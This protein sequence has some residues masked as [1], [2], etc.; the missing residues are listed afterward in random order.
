MKCE[1]CESVVEEGTRECPA[2][3]AQI[4]TP[5]IEPKTSCMRKFQSDIGRGR[6]LSWKPYVCLGWILFL[7]GVINSI[8]EIAF[9][10]SWQHLSLESI[11]IFFIDL[12]P[13]N[14]WLIIGY[15]RKNVNRRNGYDLLK[16][17]G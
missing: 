16:K 7:G 8:S 12:I 13:C 1:Y 3:G 14:I 2:C 10:I 17:R 6:P 4:D 5:Y 9:I 11:F 15:H